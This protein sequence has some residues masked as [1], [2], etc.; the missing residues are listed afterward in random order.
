MKNFDHCAHYTVRSTVRHD[1]FRPVSTELDA[2][3][4]TKRVDAHLHQYRMGRNISGH[5][6]QHD[7]FRLV[8]TELDALG[9][10]KHVDAHPHQYSF[11]R[12]ISGHTV[13]HDMFRLVSTELDASVLLNASLIFK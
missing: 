3:G 10:I 12:N 9:A 11:G 7:V 5:T 2:L 6:V 13:W 8:S 4:A 1:T